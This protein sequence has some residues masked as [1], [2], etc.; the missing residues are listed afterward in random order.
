[1]TPAQFNFLID[2]FG[3]VLGKP[4]IYTIDFDADFVTGNL[5]DAT[6]NAAALDQ[7][8]F[9]TDHD[10]TL[11]LFADALFASPF[12]FSAIVTGPRQ[13]TVKASKNKV[14]LDISSALVTGGASQPVAT[15]TQTQ[16]AVVIPVV[17]ADQDATIQPPYASIRL[18]PMTPYG[19]DEVRDVDP[20]TQLA[21]VCGQRRQAVRIDYFGAFPVQGVVPEDAQEELEKAY[22]AMDRVTVLDRFGAVGLALLQKLGIQNLTELV[23][24]RYEPHATFD[25][26]VGFAVSSEDDVGVIEGVEAQGDY[27]GGFDTVEIESDIES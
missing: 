16:A 13:I 14:L 12:I 18:F 8:A 10:T 6:V 3:D 5:I 23:N 1:M 19:R 20:V 27:E 26:A 17:R 24:T 25:F 22:I 21:P 11:Q 9:D 4:D 2:F 15:I 7:V